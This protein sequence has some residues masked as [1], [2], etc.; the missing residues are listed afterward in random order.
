MQ[1][2]EVSIMPP[3]ITLPDKQTRAYELL[4]LVAAVNNDFFG[5]IICQHILGKSFAK[6]TGTTCD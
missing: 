2:K 3:K 4:E 1:K 5:I 6:R